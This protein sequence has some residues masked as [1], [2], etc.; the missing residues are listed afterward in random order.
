VTEEGKQKV[1]CKIV[2]EGGGDDF[3]LLKKPEK[4]N[5]SGFFVGFFE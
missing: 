5:F 1:K 3:E 4:K 2:K